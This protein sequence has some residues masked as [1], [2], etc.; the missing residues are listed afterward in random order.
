MFKKHKGLIV[1]DMKGHL[2]EVVNE[3]ESLNSKI[4]SLIRLEI[5]W[6]LSELGEDG[7]TA[8]QIKSGL[9][10]RNDGTT[11]SNLNAL[12]DMEY[13]KKEFVTFE[14]KELEVYSI[15]LE[16]LEEWNKT[17]KWLDMLVCGD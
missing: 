3:A 12:V 11:Y 15:T 5:M 4:F 2:L 1:L 17:K 8:R 9:K 7:A 6:A 10:I 13:L 14:S 16:G